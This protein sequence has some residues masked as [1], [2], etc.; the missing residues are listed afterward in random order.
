VALAI[1]TALLVHPA[2]GEET[3][4]K[5]SSEAAAHWAFQ[6][7]TDPAV[8][9]VQD[10]AWA[11][12]DIDRFILARLERAA[13][14]PTPPADKRTLIRR[15]TFD[16]TGLPPTPEE[17]DAFLADDSPQAFAK[18]VER[19]LASRQ[20]GEKWG[21]HWLDLV[22]YA[23]TAGETADFPVPH[24]WR[25][26]NYV[27]DA[28][29]TDKPYDQFLREQVAGDILASQLPPEASP[30]QYRELQV[31]TGYISI[32]RRF[33]FDSDKDLF[34]TIDDTLDTLSKSVLGLAL[35]CAR[36]HD[37]K[38]DPISVQD[39]YAL[40]GIFES[41]RYPFPGC[42]KTKAP[43]DMVP[44]MKP[45]DW[46]RIVKPH[47]EQIA[48]IDRKQQELGPRRAAAAQ[49][50]K[51]SSA[52]SRRELAAGTI[53]N[54]GMQAVTQADGKP[55]SEIDVRPGDLVLLAILPRGN[56]GADSTTVELEIADATG[57][58]RRWNLTADVVDD[59]HSG[60]PHA[61]RLGHQRTWCFLDLR[62]GAAFLSEPV[63]DIEQ[64]PGLNVWRLG[65]LPSALVNQ[66]NDSI[67]AWTATFPPRSFAVHPS[68]AGGVGVAWISPIEGRIAIT[69][70]VADADAAGGD[71]VDWRLEQYAQVSG[72]LLALADV[73]A[74]LA[75]LKKE[76]D[77]LTAQ[78]PRYDLAY[79]VAEGAPHDA[80]IQRRGDPDNRGDFVPRRFLS[81]LGGAPVPAES[82]SGRLALADWLTARDNPLTPRVFVNRLWQHHLG[83]GLVNTPSDFGLRGAEPTHP[84][85]I[86]F[87]ARRFVE[88]GWSIKAMHRLIMLSAV[89]QQGAGDD[90]ERSRV[91]PGNALWWRFKPRR[92]SAEE[93]RDTIL[94][95]TGELDLTP[96]GPHPFPDEKTWGFTQ[97]GPFNAVYDHNQRS[98]YLMTQ[99]IKRHPFLT[100]F[101]GPDANSSTA[102]RFSTT[103]P[104][105]ALFFTND[106]FVHA[107]ADAF[108]G[109]LLKLADDDARLDRTWRLAFSR[110][111]NAEERS[112]A[113]E[114]L[115]DYSGQLTEVPEG[116]RQ[117]QAWAAW[118]RVVLSSN[119]LIYID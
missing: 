93:I 41:T 35:G 38:Y 31:A 11:Q 99:R 75:G 85:L 81:I 37:H 33:G 105:Q 62:D 17:V 42:E 82:G 56:H 100:L 80:Q 98:V 57:S 103:V 49:K 87:L 12:T 74:E 104:T 6:P 21:R 32:A 71:G 68:A 20:Y 53:D 67:K 30:E 92:L 107:K 96:G 89:Y 23:D 86:D 44:L 69:G 94:S 18:L 4:G 15:A 65:D 84:E 115:A 19:L 72:D 60:N 66:T 63:R 36:C 77:E 7:L 76:R 111:P 27:I 24:A 118:L 14:R 43:R 40:Y 1:G 61:D 46:D 83:A 78:A 73:E 28:F 51:G 110:L 95:V 47:Q 10:A 97:H 112:A 119:E 64:H 101:D 8:P 79:A 34:L 58:E 50:F 29:N 45:S 116:E 117:R 39:Y 5:G 90:P 106:P 114:F 88:S 113:R 2:T 22:R 59:L 16:L 109:R 91:D 13:L 52:S 26:R 3:A 102:D 9:D 70:R 55:L 48:G 25:Y 54:G 108:A